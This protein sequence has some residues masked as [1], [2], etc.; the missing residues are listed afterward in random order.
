MITCFM[1]TR[2]A[3]RV[4]PSELALLLVCI[5]RRVM[6]RALLDLSIVTGSMMG[7]HPCT[8]DGVDWE[9]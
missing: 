2:N 3:K 8:S 7:G 9:T 4:C 6:S 1:E 5:S